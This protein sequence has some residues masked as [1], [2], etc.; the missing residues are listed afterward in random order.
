MNSVSAPPSPLSLVR[1]AAPHASPHLLF[2]SARRSPNP[3]S[4]RPIGS[5]PDRPSPHEPSSIVGTPP[6][7]SL[8]ATSPTPDLLREPRCYS[9]C[10][11]HPSHRPC[12]LALDPA[13]REPSASH[14]RPHHRT[15]SILG[16]RALSCRHA[17]CARAPWATAMVG[18]G[19]LPMP[20]PGTVVLGRNHGPVSGF[21]SFLFDLVKFPKKCLESLK[22][23]ENRV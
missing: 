4:H 13:A 17:R 20:C 1:A 23:I 7:R 11:A 5:T 21:V 14:G 2:C 22:I 3:S 8:H 18:P 16:D 15:D 19:H 6:H 12:A 10:P 9:S